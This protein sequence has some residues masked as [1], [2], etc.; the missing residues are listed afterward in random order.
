MV[1]SRLDFVDELPRTPSGKLDAAA[2][3]EPEPPQRPAEE[4]IAAVWREV[5]GVDRVGG[6]DDF[7]ELGGDSLSAVRAVS[8]LNQLLGTDLRLAILFEA[9][10]ARQLAAVVGGAGQAP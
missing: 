3:R 8:R 9:S 10:T 6:D 1:P 5:L 2:L 4:T 7:F